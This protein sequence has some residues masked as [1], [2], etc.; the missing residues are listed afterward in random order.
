MTQSDGACRSG[1]LYKISA[2]GSDFSVLRSFSS[3]KDDGNLP[4]GKLTR[5]GEYL[6]GVTRKG[7]TYNAG[8]VFG[9]DPDGTAYTVLH[10]FMGGTTDGRHPYAGV[11]ELAGV[12]Y[13][14]T[15]EGGPSARGTVFR[16]N[17]DGT[18]YAV[19]HHFTAV[20]DNSPRRGCPA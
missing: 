9:M 15:P 13:G 8:T 12:L 20:Q 17:T 4:S 16:V 19:L 6:Y 14:T 1:T 3:Q 7:G 10:S 11:I 2:S 5:V 18:D